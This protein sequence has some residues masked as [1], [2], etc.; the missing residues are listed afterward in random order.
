MEAWLGGGLEGRLEDWRNGGLEGWKAGCFPSL[1]A[2]NPPIVHFWLF[3]ALIITLVGCRRAGQ[4]LTDIN[5]S[6]TLAPN[7]PQVG[8]MMVTVTLTDAEAQPIS[9]A[10]VELEGNMSHAGMAPVIAQAMEVGSG[11]YAAPL[12]FGMAGDWFVLVRASLPDGRK[13]EYQVNVPGVKPN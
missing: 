6:L 12:E 4:N 8:Q 1:H 2:S 5:I 13:L 11:S 9:G 10:K 7:P 3:L